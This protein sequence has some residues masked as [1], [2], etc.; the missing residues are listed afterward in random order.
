M[1]EDTE[2]GVS[3]DP[4]RHEPADGRRQQHAE[5]GDERELEVAVE[6]EQQEEDQAQGERQDHVQLLPRGGVF[7]V[8]AAPV[9]AVALRQGDLAADLPDG[10]VHR[11]GKVASLHRELHA[12]VA[13]IVL[14]VDERGAVGHVDVGELLERDLLPAGRRHQ[15]VADLLRVVAVLLLEAHDEIELLL[16]LHHLGGDVPADGGLDQGVDVG[17]V[18][19]VAGDLGAVDA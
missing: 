10:F 15:D 9:Q 2:N 13:R 14:A 11:A 18:E 1:P 17:D 19:T 7:G 8:L 3:G 5:H 4:Q 16:A 6:R 12:D